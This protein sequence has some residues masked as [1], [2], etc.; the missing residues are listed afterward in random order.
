MNNSDEVEKEVNFFK[1]RLFRVNFKEVGYTLVAV[2]LGFLIGSLIVWMSGNSPL[3]LYRG[4]YNGAFSSSFAVGSW[5]SQSAPI[6]LTSLAFLVVLKSGLYNIGAEGQLYV[7]AFAAAWAG[8]SLD[9]PPYIHLIVALLFGMGAGALWGFIPGILRAKRGANEFVTSLMLSEVAILLT[10]WFVSTG[11]PFKDPDQQA[12]LTRPVASGAR[13]PDILGSRLSIG[14][15][16]AVLAAFF[17]LYLLLK[18]S[19]GYEMRTVGTNVKAAKYSGINVQK[20]MIFSFIIGGAL[21]GL[22]GAGVTLGNLTNNRFIGRFSPGYGWDGIAGALIGRGHPIGAVFA[23]LL[24]GMLRAGA[25]NLDQFTAIPRDITL[26]IE[27]LI[28]FF[29]IAPALIEYIGKRLKE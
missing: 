29:V 12:S 10:S 20:I 8:F 1:S 14:I 24:L 4:I 7:G 16:L 5:L 25:M 23:S 22:A 2:L 15:L 13:L 19:W 21:A 9:L 27:G 11:G 18:T 28:A 26:I 3:D 6:I 17:V